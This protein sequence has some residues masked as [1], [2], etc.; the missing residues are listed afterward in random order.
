MNTLVVVVCSLVLKFPCD[1]KKGVQYELLLLQPK[2][3]DSLA[4]TQKPK[5]EKNERILNYL[6]PLQGRPCALELLGNF[7]GKNLLF[8]GKSMIIIMA[9]R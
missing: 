2:E 1:R 7:N 6:I 9:W 4:M 5:G 8:Y 3:F